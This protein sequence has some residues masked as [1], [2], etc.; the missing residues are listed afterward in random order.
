MADGYTTSATYPYA[1]HFGFG[2]DRINYLRNSVKAVIDAYDGTTTFYV[3]DPEDPIVAAYRGMFP[4]LFRD[5]SAMPATARKHVRYPELLLQVQAAV[6]GLYHMTN[7]A[8]FYNK[9]D[10][11]TVA[12][13]VGMNAQ[14]EQATQPM[15]PNFVL[16]TLP[17]EKT[18]EFVEILPFTPANRNNLIGWI[19]GRS[20]DPNYGKAIVYDFPK[21]RLVDGPLQIEARIDQ[22]A[23]LSGQLSLWNQQGSHVRR[24]GLIVIPVG[25]ALLYAEPIYLQ[26]ERSPMPE[27]RIVVL[28]LQDRL[29]Y[30]PTFESAMAGLFG[31]AAS[32][33]TAAAAPPAPP[34]SQP[35]ERA[36]PGA[37]AA[38]PLSADLN[39]LIAEAARDLS[40]YQRLTAEGKLGEAGQRLEALKQKLDRLNQ[41]RR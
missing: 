39:T 14:R 10:L 35:A 34:T 4:S 41:L 15:E 17:G 22:N 5:M 30:G 26:A 21:T 7:P 23:Q 19:A 31:G 38:A 36:T 27:L 9:E 29:A 1:R 12:S 8:V 18:S 32:S 33:L 24:G 6:Y 40:E 13:E 11:W 2:R 3:F 28:A 25:R 16:M 37:T 20:D